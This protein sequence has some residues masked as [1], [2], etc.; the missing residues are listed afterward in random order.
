MK[1]YIFIIIAGL[2]I[3]LPL[4]SLAAGPSLFPTG[5]WGPL[6]SC[7]GSASSSEKNTLPVC[8]TFCDMVKTAQYVLYFA[9][10]ILFFL[11]VPILIAFGGLLMLISGGSEERFQSGRKYATSGLIALLIGMGA[12]LIISTFL[13]GIGNG[14]GNAKVSWPTIEC[15]PAQPPWIYN[16]QGSQSSPQSSPHPLDVPL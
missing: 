16:P 4:I 14:Q 7:T 15:N 12:F 10:T 1:K 13:W 5:Y 6:V 3:L 9:M 11:I 2:L 8:T